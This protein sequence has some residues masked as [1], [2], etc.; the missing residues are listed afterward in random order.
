MPVNKRDMLGL[1]ALLSHGGSMRWWQTIGSAIE[2]R[3]GRSL[4]SEYELYHDYVTQVAL[5]PYRNIQRRWFRF[6]NSCSFDQQMYLRLRFDFASYEGWDE[7]RPW[8]MVS[9]CERWGD[10]RRAAA[11]AARTRKQ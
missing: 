8:T 11:Q 9:W 10:L 6:G 5:R 7:A 4:F 3:D 1:L 2:G